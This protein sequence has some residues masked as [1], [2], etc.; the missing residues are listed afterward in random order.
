M[1]FIMLLYL[2]VKGQTNECPFVSVASQTD[3]WFLVY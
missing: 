2:Y 3:L 1:E